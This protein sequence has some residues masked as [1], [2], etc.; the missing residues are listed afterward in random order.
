MRVSELWERP[1]PS[2]SRL[3]HIEHL[4]ASR[5]CLIDSR[6][7]RTAGGKAC[8]TPQHTASTHDANNAISTQESLVDDMYAQG[9]CC[10]A[11]SSH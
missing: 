9:T 1:A 8:R 3:H 5:D 10:Q 11:H 4:S 7:D 6:Y 2:T